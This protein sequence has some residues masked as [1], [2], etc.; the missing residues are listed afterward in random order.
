MGNFKLIPLQN[1]SWVS[2]DNAPDTKKKFTGLCRKTDH[3]L[4]DDPLSPSPIHW[5]LLDSHLVWRWVGLGFRAPTMELSTSQLAHGTVLNVVSNGEMAVVFST[6]HVTWGG[7]RF[8]LETCWI[9]ATGYLT[10]LEWTCRLQPPLGSFN[11]KCKLHQNIISHVPETTSSFR[12]LL[13]HM[14]PKSLDTSTGLYYC[15]V[16]QRFDTKES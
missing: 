4:E 2:Q 6:D 1:I 7:R 11:L 12:Q 8:C 13:T 10:L 15:S 3:S 5:H 9:E 14:K 16:L